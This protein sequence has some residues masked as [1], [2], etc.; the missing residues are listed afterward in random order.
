MQPI[1]DEELEGFCAE[2]CRATLG[3][4]DAYKHAETR[5]WSTSIIDR[6]INDLSHRSGDYKFVVHSIILERPRKSADMAMRGMYAATGAHWDNEIDGSWS[7]KYEDEVKGIDVV[8]SII[9]IAA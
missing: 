3:D 9:W 6:L 1:S 8:I 5:E 4:V 2:A 7:Y